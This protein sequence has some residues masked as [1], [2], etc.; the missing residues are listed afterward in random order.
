M[1]CG[2]ENIAME[3]KKGEIYLI[4]TRG[5]E[6][7]DSENIRPVVI[8]QNNIAN[9]YAPTLIVASITSAIRKVKLPTQI[10]IDL[11]I[12]GIKQKYIILLECIMTISKERLVR[13]IGILSESEIFSINKALEI[14]FDIRVNKNI[15]DEKKEMEEYIRNISRPLILTEGKTD[16][17]IIE[18]AWNK[19]YPDKDM[20]FECIHAGIEFD[21]ENRNGGVEVLRRELEFSAIT[22][23]R[24]II[25]IFDNDIEGNKAFRGLNEKIFEKCS[26]E[27]GV[28]KH[29]DTNVWG[30]LLP[31]PNNRKIFVTDDDVKQRYLVIEH[32][33]SDEI[34]KKYNM[35]G[36]AILDSSL[37]QIKNGKNRFSD[38]IKKL[39]SKEFENF[40]ILFDR[41]EELVKTAK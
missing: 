27:S 3:F 28:R 20:F 5:M 25:G 17:K 26:I 10:E 7:D 37:F 38:D 40:R 4:K 31:V 39:D 41:L 24:V 35:Y 2:K 36:K 18:T 13:K 22:A 23:N 30:M 9:K 29:K 6:G 21:K 8:V 16:V 34:L 33:F 19:L 1:Q 12:E 14:N 32:Y 11:S 15:E